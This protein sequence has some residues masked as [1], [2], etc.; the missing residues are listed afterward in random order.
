MIK[1]F[2]SFVVFRLSVTAMLPPGGWLERPPGGYARSYLAAQGCCCLISVSPLLLTISLVSLVTNLLFTLF[3]ALSSANNLVFRVWAVCVC[4]SLCFS[5]CCSLASF[6]WFGVWTFGID[7]LSLVWNFD[8]KFV[9]RAFRNYGVY[10][11]LLA[12]AI[13]K[14]DSPNNTRL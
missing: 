8:L 5:K 11:P 3:Q 7:L 14:L 2:V 12:V 9:K 13:C 10:K 1:L 4:V 6:G